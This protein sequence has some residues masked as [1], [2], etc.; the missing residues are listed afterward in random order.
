LE[1]CIE[2]DSGE[3]SLKQTY[4]VIQKPSDTNSNITFCSTATDFAKEIPDSDY[5]QIDGWID[6]NIP[7]QQ[8]VGFLK[9]IY[10]TAKDGTQVVINSEDV[11]MLL[12][13]A[14]HKQATAEDINN[15]LVGKKSYLSLSFIRQALDHIG[16]K[17]TFCHYTQNNGF[18]I[19]VK[20]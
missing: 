17:T 6:R 14:S 10:D 12:S 4:L 5:I 1:Q 3:L 13:L 8:V 16:F 9:Y 7:Y 19:G 20:K 11:T 2:K 18:S 15:T